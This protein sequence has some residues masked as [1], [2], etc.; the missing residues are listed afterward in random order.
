MFSINDGSGDRLVS[1]TP[2]TLN[3]FVIFMRNSIF[4]ASVGVGAYLLGDP[5][6]EDNSYVKSLA[7]DIGCLA[8]RSVVQAGGGIIFLSDNGVYLLNPSSASGASQ[9]SPEGM[10]LLTLAEPLSAQI[11]DVI[12]RIN[13]NFAQNSVAIYWENRYYLAVPLDDSEVNNVIL[14]YNF[15]NKSWESIDTYPD[16]FDVHAFLIA[17]KDNKRRI[18]AIDPNEGVFLLEENEWDEFGE[19]SG[20]PILDNDISKLNSEGCRFSNFLYTPNQIRAE[21][22]TRAYIFQTSGDKRFSSIQSDVDFPGF[23]QIDIDFITTNPDTSTR[24]FDF[25][26]EVNEDYILRLPTR[27][28]AYSAQVKYSVNSLRP[29]IRSVFVEAILVGHNIHTKS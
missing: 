27:K 9:A 20:T 6:Q 23:G 26:P 4:Y 25:S 28:V 11:D 7:T 21:L 17:K 8:K 15:L 16:E 13:S 10:R 1:I 19:G 2:W 14:V 12:A 18:W 5:A 3:E 24:M 29:S 22:I